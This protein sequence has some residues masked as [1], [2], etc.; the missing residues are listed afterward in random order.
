MGEAYIVDA[1]RSAIGKKKGTL[2]AT[3]GD[4]LVA[5]VMKGLVD[6]TGVPIDAVEDVVMGCVTQVGEQGWNIGRMAALIAGFPVETCS[7]S[8][9]RMC[10]SSLQTTNFAAQ[11]IMAGQQDVVISAGTECMSRVLM[12]SDGGDLSSRLTD[13]Y[14]IVP[15]G[16]SAEMIAEQWGLTRESLDEFSYNSHQR[17]LAA[18][19]AGK[20]DNEIIPVEVTNPEGEKVT[21]AK[22]E[23]PRVTTLEKMGM[24]PTV[25]KPEGGTVTAGNASQ[26]CDGAA[27]LL[28]VSG[29]ALE[30]YGLTPRAKVISTGL[31]G[32]DPTIMLSGNPVAIQRALDRVQLTLDDMS[33]VEVNEAFASVALQTVKDL[34]FEDRMDDFNPNGGGISLGHPLGASGARILATLLNELERRDAKYGVASMCIGFGM[35]VATVIERV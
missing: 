18:Q 3:R 26:I 16:F 31:H 35:A 25:F 19:E 23:T 4:D 14:S 13:K 17:A 15:Q 11:A 32:V 30:Q 5:D 7:T 34:K 20:F 12:G 22:D 6:R 1:V 27:A 10:G 8:V 33:V 28:L 29:A 24:L 9:N 21:F 2:S